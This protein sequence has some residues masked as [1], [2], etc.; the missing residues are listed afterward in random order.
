[1]NMHVTGAGPG[2]LHK[3]FHPSVFL[4]HWVSF[5]WFINSHGKFNQPAAY[6]LYSAGQL[7]QNIGLDLDFLDLNSSSQ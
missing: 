3:V 5:Q 1:M 6:S 2:V 4:N 7:K